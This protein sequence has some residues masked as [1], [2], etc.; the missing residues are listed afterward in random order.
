MPTFF[1]IQKKTPTLWDI[2]LILN[3]IS[4]FKNGV[5]GFDVSK[6][7]PKLSSQSVVAVD[8]RGRPANKP[9]RGGLRWPV[10]RR[11]SCCNVQKKFA[12]GNEERVADELYESRWGCDQ[13]RIWKNKQS[14]I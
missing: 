14:E 10:S 7:N 2:K 5:E 13:K 4:T 9:Y 1:G 12:A 6:K 3:W 8:R 11:A